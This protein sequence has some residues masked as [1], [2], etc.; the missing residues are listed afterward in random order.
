MGNDDRPKRT[1][2]EIDKLRAGGTS[3]SSRGGS[4][5]D[6]PGPG[7]GEEARQKQ[8]RA[9]LEAAFA[10]GELGKLADKL[11]LSGRATPAEETK[12]A[13]AAV[14]A[15][16]AAPASPVPPSAGSPTA[17]AA[18]SKGASKKKPTEDKATLMRKLVEAG[19]RQEISR[20][21]EKYLGRF[22]MPDDHEFL[23][24]LLEHEKETRIAEA[25]Q[26][27]GELLDRRQVPRRTRALIGKLRYLSETAGNEELR[28]RA[29]Q[30]LLRLS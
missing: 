30:L 22:P 7:S 8:Y 5:N 6:R 12:N 28:D 24:Q 10:K 16:P 3:H 18:A 26:R 15:P 9:A 27:I 4:A 11:S 25:M 19:N 17:A 23:E 14:S 13:P 2:R 1:W 21:A 29:K 20:A